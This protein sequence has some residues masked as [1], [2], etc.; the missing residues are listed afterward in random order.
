MEY[1]PLLSECLGITPTIS[2]LSFFLSHPQTDYSK[3]ELAQMTSQTRQTV[4]KGINPLIEFGLIKES[5][6]I[7]HTQLY[8]LNDG[9][10]EVVAI[11]QFNDIIINKISEQQMDFT[12]ES[13]VS[14]DEFLQ[15]IPE[16]G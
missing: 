13:E 4:Y 10:E 2:L 7:G 16:R 9:S 14:P 8:I 6:R 15:H 11:K 3:K 12:P 1:Y 5:R